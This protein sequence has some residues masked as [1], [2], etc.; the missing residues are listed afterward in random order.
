MT[1]VVVLFLSDP[2]AMHPADKADV[3]KLR[4]RFRRAGFLNVVPTLRQRG[5]EAASLLE[6][7]LR[8]EAEFR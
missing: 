2:A 8:R 1:C 7:V 6:A 3:K 4:S 5:L